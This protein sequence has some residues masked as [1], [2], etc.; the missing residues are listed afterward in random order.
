MEQAVKDWGLPSNPNPPIVTDNASNMDKAG[1]MFKTECHIKCYAHT[2]NL[3]V[4]KSLKVKQV[5]HILSRMK[6]IVAFSIEA[7]LQPQNLESKLIFYN[8]LLTN[9]QLI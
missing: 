6:K 7:L 1:I 2:L 3:A 5:S 8:Y 4:Q 9:Y